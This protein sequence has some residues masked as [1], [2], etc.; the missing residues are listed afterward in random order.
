MPLFLAIPGSR[1]LLERK[2]IL[3]ILKD[4]LILQRL[5]HYCSEKP[6]SSQA[7]AYLFVESFSMLVCVA[8]GL[9][10]GWEP[11]WHFLWWFLWADSIR[12]TEDFHLVRSCSHAKEVSLEHLFTNQVGF[13]ALRRSQAKA[14]LPSNTLQCPPSPPTHTH[15]DTQTHTDPPVLQV[16]IWS[17]PVSLLFCQNL[18]KTFH[19]AGFYVNIVLC[20]HTQNKAR[21]TVT[22]QFYIL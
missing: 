7:N 14:Q 5:S 11:Y 18:F 22:N 19:T 15:A 2:D 6:E 12:I 21:H 4:W 8:G 10:R 1:R 20:V 16:F 9:S 3:Q 13:T 17:L